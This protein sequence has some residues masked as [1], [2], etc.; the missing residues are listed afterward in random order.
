MYMP[1]AFEMSDLARMH[2]IIRDHGFATLIAIAEGEPFVS[3]VPLI[4][5]AGRGPQGTLR[6]HVAKA[7]PHAG[8]IIAGTPMLAIFQ[9]P[10]GYVSPTWYRERSRNVPTWNYVAIHASGIPRPVDAAEEAERL[11]GALA[12][13]YESG[14]APWSPA[15]ME[16][17]QRDAMRKAIVCFEVP[18]DRIEGKFKLSQN[19]PEPDRDGVIRGLEAAGDPNSLAL[20]RVMTGR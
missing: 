6:G 11:L 14:A 2:A 18:I 7:N 16:Q 4:L 8:L 15:E 1:P 9:G 3:H 5:D 19:K 10:H 13:S 20:A 12:A 17:G